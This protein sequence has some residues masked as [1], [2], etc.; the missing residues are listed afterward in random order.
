MCNF[1]VVYVQVC[2]FYLVETGGAAAFY[3]YCYVMSNECI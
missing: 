2:L 1:L 3:S